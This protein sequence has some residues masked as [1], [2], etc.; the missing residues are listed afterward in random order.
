M[1][2]PGA[3]GSGNGT[4]PYNGGPKTPVPMP[5]AGSKTPERAPIPEDDPQASRT[6]R[7]IPHNSLRAT[8]RFVSLPVEQ[9]KTGKWVYPAYGEMP[10]R[11]GSK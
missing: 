3:P 10:R 5:G 11:T 7:M 8:E 2:D 6:P 1:L 4:Y 9:K